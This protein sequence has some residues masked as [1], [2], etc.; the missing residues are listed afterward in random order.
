MRG[1]L[2][3]PGGPYLDPARV[4]LAVGALAAHLR[5]DA[6]LVYVNASANFEAVLGDVKQVRL[7][8]W[9]YTRPLFSST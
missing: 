8:P 5:V 1:R 9:A 2:E 4:L 6:L 7:D 3:C